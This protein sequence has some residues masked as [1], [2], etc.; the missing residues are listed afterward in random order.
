[1]KLNKW[2][3]IENNCSKAIMKC[4]PS[5]LTLISCQFDPTSQT[6]TTNPLAKQLFQ[7]TVKIDSLT[8]IYLIRF[9]IVSYRRS[10]WWFH[11]L[12]SKTWISDQLFQTQSLSCLSFLFNESARNGKDPY[13]FSLISQQFTWM[14]LNVAKKIT[15]S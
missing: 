9:K 10:F 5:F 7:P 12:R 4:V 2:K 14:S 15:D 6:T 11:V 1:M 3:K 13:L 8:A